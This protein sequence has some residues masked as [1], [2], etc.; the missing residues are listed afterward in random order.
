M[1]KGLGL[2]TYL[3]RDYDEAI[4]WFTGALGFALVEDASLGEGK[5]WVVVGPS[6]GDGAQLLLARAAGDHQ[7]ARIGDQA[8]GR[9]FLFLYTDDIVRDRAMME[10]EGVSFAE[11]IRDEAYGRVCVFVDLYGAKWD[12]IE[13]A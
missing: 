7:A 4:A 9:V 6:D 3:V 13:R 8:G 2:V 1:R 10:A 11:P 5:R 12:L